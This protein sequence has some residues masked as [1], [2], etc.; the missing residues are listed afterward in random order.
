MPIAQ[1]ILPEFDL[2]MQATRSVLERVPTDELGWKPHDKSMTLVRLATHLARLPEWAEVTLAQDELDLA[3]PEAQRR[4]EEPASAEEI[5]SIFDESVSRARS[6]IAA[7][8]DEEFG[9]SWSLKTGE[10]VRFTAPRAAVL[11]R[12]VLNHMIHHRGQLTVFLRLL[13]VPVPQTFGPTADEPDF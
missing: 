7:T 5:L 9:R 4:P 6:K 2:E 8:S 1:T 3:S 13:D 10:E 12:F 11:R